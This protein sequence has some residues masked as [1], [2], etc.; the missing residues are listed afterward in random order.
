M[1]TV[2]IKEEK[3]IY[4]I[5]AQK[6]GITITAE[7]SIEMTMEEAEN[8]AVAEVLGGVNQLINL[9]HFVALPITTEERWKAGHINF[10]PRCGK[11]ISEFG[12]ED[13]LTSDC[14]NCGA[15]LV[16]FVHVEN[17]EDQETI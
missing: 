9:K 13:T 3:Q 5:I 4:R 14:H 10:C 1:L 16:V 15:D 8:T 12:Y 7:T 2:S 17:S 6:Q 11:N